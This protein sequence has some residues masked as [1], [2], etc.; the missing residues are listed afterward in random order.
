MTYRGE[1]TELRMKTLRQVNVVRW[2]HIARVQFLNAA[3]RPI[4]PSPFFTLRFKVFAASQTPRCAYELNIC[5]GLHS[6]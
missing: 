6:L 3:T 5:R 1:C 2:R 4:P